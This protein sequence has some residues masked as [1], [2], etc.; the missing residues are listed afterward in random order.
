[1]KYYKSLTGEV[2]AYEQDGS[3]DDFILPDLIPM[4]SEE[5]QAH[6]NPPVTPE[7]SYEELRAERERA[8]AAI[9]V[10]TAA[11]HTF[12]GDEISQ[13][14]MARAILGLQS[15]PASETTTWVLADNRVVQVGALEL[16]EA[17][18]LAGTRQTELWVIT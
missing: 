3:Q 13:G 7:H 6:L 18:A 16:T 10:T 8:V 15:K 11:G 14:R 5:V 12:D 1:M 17:L 9:T 4:T 2:F